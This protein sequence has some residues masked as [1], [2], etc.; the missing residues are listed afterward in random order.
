MT[1]TDERTLVEQLKE[2]RKTLLDA[3]VTFVDARKETRAQIED[4][5]KLTE[6][7]RTAYAEAERQFLVDVEARDNEIT[8][9]DARIKSEEA[10]EKRRAEA[11]A[12]APLISG[13]K[14]P[15]TYRKD[16]T[17]EASWLHDMAVV[18]DSRTVGS[19]RG[20]NPTASRE[21]LSRH[22]KEMD[23]L[24]PKRAAERERRALEI[25]EQ[26]IPARE[27]RSFHG[28]IF[29]RG[30][31][32][33]SGTEARV[34]PNITFGQGGEFVPPLWLEQDFIPYLR[35]GRVASNLVR[36]VPLPEGTDSINLPKVSTPTL[37]GVQN[38]NN[39]PVVSQD[40]QTTSVATGVKTLAGQEDVAIQL[41]E[42]SPG[43]ISERM[44]TEDLMAAYNLCLDQQVV[45][46]T[47]PST[48]TTGGLLGLYPASNWSALSVTNTQATPTGPTTFQTFGVQA[49]Q[50]AQNRYNNTNIQFLVHP[51]RGYAY[52]TSLDGAS[53]K[54]FVESA[55]FYP[56]QPGAV[57]ETDVAEGLI[58]RLPFGPGIYISNNVP[59]TANTNQDP[60]I[61]FKT[62]D[63][64]LFEGDM[65][66]RVL[67]EVLSGT[68]QV[69]F[70]AYNYVGMI[71]RYGGSIAIA[72]GT[73]C[74]PPTANAG[75]Y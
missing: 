12:H 71:V 37:V 49:S 17:Q 70:Q 10:I 43:G 7:E 62:D 63:V 39:V 59:T 57:E 58:A 41:L 55:G 51:R 15:A 30:G 69:R 31:R 1:M 60:F 28:E 36:Q 34:N 45:V 66:V 50:I 40:I 22:G 72:T 48:G 67:Q 18:Y 44:I 27:R 21:R 54:P 20:A 11:A 5:T 47:G 65:R 38:A 2:Q 13:I 35:A 75:S 29:E 9:L 56:F 16:N 33:A 32:V 25:I 73:G 53:S 74:A 52:V 19:L 6:D 26:G 14:E 8:E 68:L 3:M 24:L 46:G 4:L 42:L 23:E 64:W 61:A